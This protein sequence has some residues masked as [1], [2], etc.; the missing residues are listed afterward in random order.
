MSR[1]DGRTQ[2]RQLLVLV[3][4]MAPG[5]GLFI[6]GISS[7]ASA[8]HF[9]MPGALGVFPGLALVV[10]GGYYHYRTEY[11]DGPYRHP[12]VSFFGLAA[13]SALVAYLVNHGLF[14]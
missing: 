4:L 12:L 2:Y 13:F 11:K 5:A 8:H 9:G 3:A 7:C 10:A 1:K 6:W 14:R